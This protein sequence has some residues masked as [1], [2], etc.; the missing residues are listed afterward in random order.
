MRNLNSLCCVTVVETC[1]RGR[2]KAWVF[3][4]NNPEAWTEPLIALCFFICKTDVK[5]IVGHLPH[6]AVVKGEVRSQA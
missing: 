2:Q 4:I 6:R 5:E 3:C 1:A